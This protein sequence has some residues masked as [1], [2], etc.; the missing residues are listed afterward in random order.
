[1]ASAKVKLLYTVDIYERSNA[2]LALREQAAPAIVVASREELLAEL[3]GC[4]C[5]ITDRNNRVYTFISEPDRQGIVFQ[6][7]YMAYYSEDVELV[8]DAWKSANS[9]QIN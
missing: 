7:C 8:F 4:Q 2:G 3:A 5:D 6:Y 1:M 9:N